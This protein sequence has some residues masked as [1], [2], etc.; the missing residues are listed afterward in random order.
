MLLGIVSCNRN[1]KFISSGGIFFWESSKSLAFHRSASWRQLYVY[2]QWRMTY[3]STEQAPRIVNS[4][5]NKSIL[6]LHPL[7]FL[8]IFIYT[9]IKVEKNRHKSRLKCLKNEHRKGER[10]NSVE[11]VI[12]VGQCQG[13]RALHWCR[14]LF[15]HSAS[16]RSIQFIHV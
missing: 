6:L 7:L 12:F 13:W 1:T 3:Q 14:Y 5:R 8:S 16:N 15:T 2:M 10:E 9:R 4:Y 11:R